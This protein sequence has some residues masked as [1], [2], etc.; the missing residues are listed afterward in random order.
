MI[1]E[2]K[3]ELAQELAT[4][5]SVECEHFKK[6]TMKLSKEEIYSK[7]YI[8]TF[9]EQW[10]IVSR[11]AENFHYLDGEYDITNEKVE[12]ILKQDDLV[13]DMYILFNKYFEP[14]G[15]SDGDMLQTLS[16]Y[17]REY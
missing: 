9:Y 8:I 14:H 16:D 4:K 10:K 2:L 3:E 12:E 7:S 17:I 5:I 15:F 1:D 6:E 11:H 13:Y